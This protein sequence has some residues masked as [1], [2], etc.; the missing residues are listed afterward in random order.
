MRQPIK[1]DRGSAITLTAI[2][3]KFKNSDNYTINTLSKLCKEEGIGTNS[4]IKAIMQCLKD[5][6]C[7][8]NHGRYGNKVHFVHQFRTSHVMSELYNRGVIS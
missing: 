4:Q 1:A 6:G 3:T 7:V 8:S 5:M 2:L